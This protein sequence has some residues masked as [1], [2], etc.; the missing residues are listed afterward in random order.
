M[1]KKHHDAEYKKFVV[2]EYLKGLRTVDS[3][4]NE[5][6]VAPSTVYKWINAYKK[7]PETAFP[8]SGRLSDPERKDFEKRIEGLEMELA[9]LKNWLAY[10]S[11]TRK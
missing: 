7:S 2:N 9:I 5:A 11:K 8:G 4:A 1:S 3:I 6:D 10:T